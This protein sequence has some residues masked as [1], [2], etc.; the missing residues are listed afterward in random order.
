MPYIGEIRVFAGNFAPA[1]WV[2][3][4]GS[5]LSIAQYD[6][7]YTLIGTTYGGD[8]VNTF[9]VPDLSSRVPIGTGT[10]PG[11]PTYVLGQAG[12]TELNTLTTNNIPHTHA[13]TG[14]AGMLT[15]SE[16]GHK[17]TTA[18]NFPAVNGDRIYSTTT[19]NSVMAPAQL[20]LTTSAAG[21]AGAL[22]ISNIQPYLAVSYIICTEGIYPQPN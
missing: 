13:I 8:G 1:G 7:L 5:T 9:N 20:N 22:P 17:I 21:T 11:G 6:V 15:S 4:N 10:M 3:C 12:G 14:S 19:D 18:G 16:D 2:F